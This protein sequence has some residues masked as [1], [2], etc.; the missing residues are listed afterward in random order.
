[1]RFDR[2]EIIRPG[3]SSGNNM[4]V[5]ATLSSGRTI[6]GFATDNLYGGDWDWDLGPTWNYLVTADRPFLVDAGRR[7]KG[8]EL[9]GMI[10]SVG[11]NPRD[12]DAIVVSH[13]HEDHDGGILEL[14]GVTQAR[15]KAH[16]IYGCLVRPLA[17]SAPSSEKA[18]FPV[19]CWCCPMPASF[20]RHN[21]LEYHE[22]R[23]Q[24]NI[25][26][27]SMNGEL[28]AGIEVLHTPGH[29]PD[30]VALLIDREALLPGDTILPDISPHPSQERF[31]SVMRPALP[32]N[33]KEAQ[34]LFGLR[35]YVRSLKRIEQLAG[36]S[37]DILVLSAHRLYYRDRLNLLGLKDRVAEL[38]QHHRDRC[39][40]FA[41]ILSTGPKSLKEVAAEHFR[42]ELLKGHGINLAADEVASHCELM[43]AGGDVV[44]GEEGKI[45][46]TGTQNFLSLIDGI[47]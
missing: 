4:I 41:R 45:M 32:G 35:A 13:G 15:V 18:Q 3:D 34:Q 47:R 29:S 17:K 42:P 9:I 19:S 8:R 33:W 26:P 22:E 46:S 24:L 10:E 31:F 23:P 16:E 14:A 6:Y 5:R 38:V 36:A 1:M 44:F 21:C 40:D 30:A 25:E 12:I 39:S 7:G 2:I 28:G 11:F 37:E 43:E 20:A 27:M